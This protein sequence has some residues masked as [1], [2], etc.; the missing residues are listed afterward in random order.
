[1][2]D[3]KLKKKKSKAKSSDER[4]ST[5]PSYKEYS[6]DTLTSSGSSAKPVS[7]KNGIG[8]QMNATYGAAVR[9]NT[10]SFP[11][12]GAP[13]AKNGDVTAPKNVKTGVLA[14]KVKVKTKAA[15]KEKSRKLAK[16]KTKVEYLT[17][18][19]EAARRYSFPVSLVLMAVCA[20]V[21]IMAIITTGVQINE[22]TA[23]NSSLKSQYSQLEELRDELSRQL[24]VRDDL[25]V[26]ERMAKEDLGM[27]KRDQVDRYYLTVHKEDRIEII[28]DQK[29]ETTSFWDDIKNAGGSLV[30]R[31]LN[32]F[33]AD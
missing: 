13:G 17:T 16:V 1:M 18:D 22:I 30:E 23:Q 7:H 31:I 32:F 28:E 8:Q 9:T 3:A 6:W 15:T 24:E 26:V 11:N 25:R 5:H 14:G 27:V 10:G 20:T 19:V 29:Q 33:S 2:T 4:I 21:L 12:V